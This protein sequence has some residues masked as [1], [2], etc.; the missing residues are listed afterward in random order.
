MVRELARRTGGRVA[1]V[2]AAGRVLA[3]SDPDAR[4]PLPA[5]RHSRVVGDDAVVVSHVPTA[6]G[7]VT[8]VLDK[9]LRDSRA[10]AAVVRRALPVAAAAGLGLAVL[11]GMALAF[12]L[13]RRLERLRRAARGLARDGIERPLELRLG[14]DEVGEVAQAL[15]AMRVRLLAQQRGRQA[16]L[17]TASHELRTPL[18]ALSGTVELLGEELARG[19]PDLD[20]ARDRAA[21]AARQTA[22]LTALAVDLLDL[23]RLEADAPLR[24]EPVDLDELV[25]T[26]AREFAR[27]DIAVASPG[28]V[29]A[30]ADPVAVARILRVLLDN[31]LRH[32]AGPVEVSLA[33][34][35]DGAL[36][37]VAD[38]G[39]GIPAP[40][41]ER[42]FGRF[43]RGSA[44]A[45]TPGFGLGLAIA[46]GLARRMGGDV[47]A[48]AAPRGAR[49]AVTLPGCP[50]A[51]TSVMAS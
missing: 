14:H 16:F 28:G 1:L 42:I 34:A 6:A 26:V 43:E 37:V 3:D 9:P 11:L 19:A 47:R 24:S 17:S 45:A 30:R 29:W 31:A 51:V 48:Q 40:E 12:G 32:G 15:E 39:P 5:L 50:A 10:A 13:L 2:S 35:G 46:R 8:L 21:A 22:R 33:G 27:A 7:R 25:R 18:A 4:S 23:G 49:L 20:A 41:R 38:A 36:L 44:G